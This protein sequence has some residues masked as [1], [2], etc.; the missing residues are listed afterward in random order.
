MQ[1]TQMGHCRIV[2]VRNNEWELHVKGDRS[3][4]LMPLVQ[5]LPFDVA[6]EVKDTI[7]ALLEKVSGRYYHIDSR[8]EETSTSPA[9]VQPDP[10]MGN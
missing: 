4:L 6:S 9:P 1:S 5:G 8:P 3:G 10:G 2:K 7:N